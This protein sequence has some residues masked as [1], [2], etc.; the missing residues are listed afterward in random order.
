MDGCYGRWLLGHV[1]GRWVPVWHMDYTRPRPAP[2]ERTLEAYLVAVLKDHEAPGAHESRPAHWHGWASLVSLSSGVA[3]HA[4]AKD[5]PCAVSSLW[6]CLRWAISII[7][8]PRDLG[9]TAKEPN[10]QQRQTHKEKEEIMLDYSG[11]TIERL[12]R[13]RERLLKFQ[14][15]HKHPEKFD[16]ALALIDKEIERRL[17]CAE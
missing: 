2:R 6:V 9:H 12:L 17:L 7:H 8:V 3:C 14:Q 5:K 16:G 10:V 4:C 13:E 11:Y 1:G 15:A